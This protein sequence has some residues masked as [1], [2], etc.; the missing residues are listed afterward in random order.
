MQSDAI[1]PATW[2]VLGYL[3]LLIVILVVA[4]YWARRHGQFD[5][6]EE[7]KFKVFDDGIPNPQTQPDHRSKRS[8]G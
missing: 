2:F 1:F 6:T 4:L 7:I 8:S 3:A 5:D